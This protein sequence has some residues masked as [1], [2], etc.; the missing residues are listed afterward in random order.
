MVLKE[1]ITNFTEVDGNLKNKL[2]LGLSLE[3]RQLFGNRK[4]NVCHINYE[5]KYI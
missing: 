1:T 4:M 5:K 2:Q 3:E